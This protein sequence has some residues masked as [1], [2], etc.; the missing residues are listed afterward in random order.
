MLLSDLN[1]AAWIF[2]LD[3]DN[4]LRVYDVLLD[5][6]SE[7]NICVEPEKNGA[8]YIQIPLFQSQI[9]FGRLFPGPDSVGMRVTYSQGRLKALAFLKDKQIIKDFHYDP[10][11]TRGMNDW[12]D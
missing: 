9:K 8:K 1:A 6:S 11:S 10:G 2:S 5:V 4:F 7:L 12:M 3:F